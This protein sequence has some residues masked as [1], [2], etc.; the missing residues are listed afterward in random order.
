[1]NLT[2]SQLYSR[3][4]RGLRSPKDNLLDQQFRLIFL[5]PML[6][7][8]RLHGNY[9]STLR[10]FLAV[11]MLK[12]I[13]VNNALNIVAIAST[14]HPLVD[15]QGKKLEVQQ[16]VKGSIVSSTSYNS[17]GK[18][19]YDGGFAQVSSPR[20]PVSSH[21]IQQKVKEKTAFIKK[22]LAADPR[23][24]KLNAYVE[25]ITLDNMID[26]PVVVGTK[27]YQV[28]TLTLAFVL[29]TALA[30]KKPL[31][32]WA[33]AQ[34]VFNVIENTKTEDAWKLFVSLVDKKQLSMTDRLIEYLKDSH[35]T[36]GGKLDTLR[37]S[38]TEPIRRFIG[39]AAVP[40]QGFRTY[41]SPLIPGTGRSTRPSDP[42]ALRHRDLDTEKSTIP[43]HY[44]GTKG[45]EYRP[46]LPFKTGSQFDIMEVVKDNLSETELFFKF[47]LNNEL[48]AS[49]FGLKL[50]PGQVSKVFSKVSNQSKLM[51]S[52]SHQNFMAYMTQNLDTLLTQAFWTIYP[53]GSD[54]SYLYVKNE[55]I[56]KEMNDEIANLI[57]ELGGA[58]ENSFVEGGSSGQENRIKE[59]NKLCQ[60]NLDNIYDQIEKFGNDIRDKMG[61]I[62]SYGFTNEQ[63]IDFYET[64][65]NISSKCSGLVSRIEDHLS[66]AIKDGDRIFKSA[67]SIITRTLSRMKDF[68][69]RS[70]TQ[71]GNNPFENISLYR[72]TKDDPDS[73]ED[74]PPKV[75]LLE[76]DKIKVYLSQLIDHLTIVILAHFH[77]AAL[78]AICSFMEYIDVEVETVSNDALDLP[79]YTLVIPVE[80]VA[81]MHAAAISK[82]WRD[83]VSGGNKQNTNL[84]DNYIKGIIKFVN[85]ILDIPNL[86]VIDSKKGHVYYK[87]Q[88][89][90]QV[91]KTNIK[92]FE[93]YVKSMTQHELQGTGNLY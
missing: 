74:P 8:K 79:N 72:N 41:V 36:I 73:N 77:A 57:G 70:Y 7:D 33:N 50:S 66:K 44:V 29:A 23:T 15:E 32:S 64:L 6:F 53:W 47:M 35:P 12:E 21:D 4:V 85:K 78:G 54:I 24:S 51:L 38:L 46:D 45:G 22:Y 28:D 58:L 82:S 30:L 75:P 88:Y 34:F 55:M 71:V 37:S 81:M 25:I 89:M 42:G 83:L 14:D 40:V 69:S 10:S 1:M 87:F 16:M 18:S 43:S 67:E 3:A 26:V 56:D 11:S 91:N 63:F 76:T 90:S 68:Y 62:R 84:T 20:F 31:N 17:G 39:K 92:T 80:T 86:I 52:Q 13:F 59:I 5:Y 9:A 49:Q 60:N 65:D 19:S 27:D 93:T 48:L 61:Q 2:G